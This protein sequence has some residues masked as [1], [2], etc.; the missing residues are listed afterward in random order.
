[1]VEV[2]ESV[3]ELFEQL[4]S[5][6]ASPVNLTSQSWSLAMKSHATKRFARTASGEHGVNGVGAAGVVARN[7]ATAP[8]C[9]WQ[10]IAAKSAM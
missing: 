3:A 6:V 5:M 8:S 9:R 10:T 4:R 1:M 2:R 7:I